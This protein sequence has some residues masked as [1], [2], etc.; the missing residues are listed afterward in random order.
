[1]HLLV[2]GLSHRTAPLTLRERVAVPLR[3][4]PELLAVLRRQRSLDEAAVLS[5]CNRTELYLAGSQPLALRSAAMD[6][7]TRRGN[8]S[9]S[10]LH[11]RVYALA[12]QEAIQHLFRV[13]SGLDSMI[14]GESEITAQVKSAY[15]VAQASGAA[16]LVLNRLFQKALHATKIVRSTTRIAEGSASIG[17]VVTALAQQHFAGHLQRCEVLLWGAGKAAEVTARHL[18]RAGIGQLWIVNRTP[19]KAQDLASLCQSG[20]LSWEQ[21]LKHLAHVDLAI[22]CTQAPHYVIDRGD[23]EDVLPKRQGRA[24]LLVDLAV[25]RNIDP[26]V[27]TCADV[28]LY[29]IDGLQAVTEETLHAR[30]QERQRCER[31]IAQQAGHFM[32]WWDAA[33]GKEATCQLLESVSSR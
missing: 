4:L 26:A 6:V 31:L 32:R 28:S 1:M 22:V 13:A 25:P 33:V 19:L 24:L 7:L 27:T 21:A 17:S 8:L 23:L 18:I 29:D 30:Q 5:T 20:W 16:G 2:V 9:A 14:L 15:L 11:D 10:Q 3:D 12:D